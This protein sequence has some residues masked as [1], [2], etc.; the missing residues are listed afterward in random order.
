MRAMFST[1]APRY[2]FITRAFSYGMDGRWKRTALELARL[3]EQ[4]VV[5]DLAAG[6]G[7]FSLMVK[8]RH[9]NSRAIAVDLTE[10]M[11]QLAQQRGVEYTIC[12]NAGMLPFPDHSFDCVFVGY[13]LRNFP[14]LEVAIQEIKR[15][16]R[17][18][19][20]LVSLD[21]FLPSNAIMRTFYLAYLYAQGAFWGT[22]LHRQPRVYTYIPDSLRHFVSIDDFSS[23]LRR[24]G[25]RRVDARKFILGGIGLHW[26]AK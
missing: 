23:L 20:L 9:P 17:P 8:Q 1:V 11:L 4:P 10:R 21:F 2:D 6:T 5:L 3:P 22:V 18:S 15:V 13:G 7:D 25:Y 12:A 14:K 26:A 24:T 16:T 19:G